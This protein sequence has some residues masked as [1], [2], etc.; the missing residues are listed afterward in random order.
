MKVPI[1]T[2]TFLSDPQL[3]VRP[4]FEN[5]SLSR[6]TLLAG[7][8]GLAL[9]SAAASD[10][11]HAQHTTGTQRPAGHKGHG[12]GTGSL[13]Q[14][15]YSVPTPVSKDVAHDPA[16]IPPPITRRVPETVRV[17]LETVETEAKL[18]ERTTFR[19]W[20]FNG[21]VPGPF[22]R[23]MVGDTVEVHLKNREDSWV[24]HNVDFHA[25]TGPGGGAE[26]TNCAPGESKA[27]QFKALNPGLYVY[28]CA[29][30]PVAMH[31][32]QGMYG[33]IL[34]EPEAGLPP[35][36]REFYVM[37]G[38]VYTRELFGTDGLLTEDYEKLLNERPEYFVLNGHVGA[39]TEH[40]PL[41]AKVGETVRIFFGVGGPNHVSSFH[42]IGEIFDRVYVNG[43]LTSP[44]Q[45]NVQTVLVPAGGAAMVEFKLEVPGRYVLVDH[46]LSR[47]ERGLAGWLDVDGA[48]APETFKV[49]GSLSRPAP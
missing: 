29:V 20:T 9:G 1:K 3:P 5:G 7:T 12:H 16:S 17:N 22:V 27:F 39:L 18:D 40:Y 43:S 13:S 15:A 35:V 33:M 23:V 8:A 21:T 26:L 32:A 14:R 48:E 28:H 30:P 11:V 19:Y 2:D 34:V 41:K 49:I 46:S 36:D 10:G 4:Q 47:V 6:R 25:A 24:M 44:P 31:M 38:E 37:Q 45:T 42:V